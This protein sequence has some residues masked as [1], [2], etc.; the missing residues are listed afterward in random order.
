MQAIHTA[1]KLFLKNRG[2]APASRGEKKVDLAPIFLKSNRNA[3]Y[4]KNIES[5]PLG[6]KA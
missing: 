4:P 6:I 3:P 5:F 1:V 2:Q